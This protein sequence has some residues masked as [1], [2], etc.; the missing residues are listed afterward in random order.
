[1]RSMNNLLGE[2]T[3]RNKLAPGALRRPSSQLPFLLSHLPLPPDTDIV[4]VL[5]P[6][7]ASLNELGSGT[8]TELISPF[9]LDSRS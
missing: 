3:F 8:L 6:G 5:G 4:N 1:M 9:R 7:Q 2:V